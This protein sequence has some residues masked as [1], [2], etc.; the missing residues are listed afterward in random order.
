MTYI[1]ISPVEGG[2]AQ[3]TSILFAGD[4][5]IE[6]WKNT[7]Q[8]YPGSVNKGDGGSTCKQWTNRID[9]WLDKYQPTTVVLVCGEND[10]AYGDSPSKAFQNFKKVVDKISDSGATPIYFG[11]KPEPSTKGLHAQ[12]RKYDAL[13]RDHYEEKSQSPFVMID[14]Y[15]V[16][17]K[18]GN[19]N[20]LYR[21]DRLHLSNEGYGYWN[22]W[23][24]AELDDTSGCRHWMNGECTLASGD[25]SNPVSTPT[26][27]PAPAP[28]KAP[29]PKTS[30]PTSISSTSSTVTSSTSTTQFCKDDENFKFKGNKNKTCADWVAKGNRNDIRKKCRKNSKNVKVMWRCPK[31]CGQQGLGY[32]DFL[33]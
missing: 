25:D 7:D 24:Q 1:G 22:T 10:L 32:C 31:T 16:F 30:A 11:T 13:I 5:D 2:E 19:P 8:L 3:A 17:V 9:Q 20:S 33:E 18:L 4:S 28:T 26:K 15:P 29:S 21:N 14:V 23:L 27:A 6:L 12:Y